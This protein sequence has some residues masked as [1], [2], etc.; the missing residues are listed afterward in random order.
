MEHAEGYGEQ[1]GFLPCL[2]DYHIAYGEHNREA[3]LHMGAPTDRIFV[4]GAP[5]TDL[6]YRLDRP[7][8]KR[9]W[10]SRMN[11]QGD[12]PLLL[13]AL[14]PDYLK[15]YAR[16]NTWLLETCQRV[17]TMAAPHDVLIKIHP[18]D[19]GTAHERIAAWCGERAG[20]YAVEGSAPM[21]EMLAISDRFLTFKSAALVEALLLD[22]PLLLLDQPDHGVWP[23]WG[24]F[25]VYRQ[26]EPDRLEAELALFLDHP[27]AAASAHERN[28]REDFIRH[29]RYKIDDGAA[30]RVVTAIGAI[31]GG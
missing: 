23:A 21:L 4:T 9:S 11:L 16:M 2:G 29:F 7:A 14:K 26:C 13:V 25:G 17:L 5:D 24:R 15:T 10:R 8:L 18:V 3:L 28:A 22:V 20:F 12:K 19:G 30:Q 6:L 1:Y 31:C 27:R